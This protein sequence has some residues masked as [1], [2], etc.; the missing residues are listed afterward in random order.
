MGQ[1]LDLITA[2][3]DDVDLSKFSLER[4]ASFCSRVLCAS[5]FVLAIV[6]LSYTRRRFI[7]FTSRSLSLLSWPDIP[8]QSG[9]FGRAHQMYTVSHLRSS[10]LSASYSRFKMTTWTMPRQKT[11]SGNAG[12]T[13][14]TTNALGVSRLLYRGRTPPNA[15]F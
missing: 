7:P 1:C 2:P 9:T 14:S 15:R 4:S 10:F 12:Q 8:S 6:L 11:F 5:L 13:S 3:E